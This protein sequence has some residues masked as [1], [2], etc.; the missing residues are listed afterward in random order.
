VPRFLI[1]ARSPDHTEHL[2]IPITSLGTFTD[3][4]LFSVNPHMH[5]IP[6]QIT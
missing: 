3:V 5:L 6:R 2:R 1:P 4:R